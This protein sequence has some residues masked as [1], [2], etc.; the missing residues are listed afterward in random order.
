MTGAW[1]TTT[2]AVGETHTAFL[3]A[4]VTSVCGVQPREAKG[5]SASFI[6]GLLHEPSSSHM[7][8]SLP[9]FAGFPLEW[10]CYGDEE[11]GILSTVKYRASYSFHIIIHA[12]NIY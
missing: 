2:Q 4:K 1:G 11:E 6:P 7:K 5:H 10:V 8:P 9:A 12:T 3:T